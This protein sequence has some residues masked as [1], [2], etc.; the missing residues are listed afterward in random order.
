M[1][2]NQVNVAVLGTLMVTARADC[3]SVVQYFLKTAL[4]PLRYREGYGDGFWQVEVHPDGRVVPGG[5]ALELGLPERID[6]LPL[7]E[8]ARL[9]EE[10]EAE[11]KKLAK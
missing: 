9:A 2:I 10:A 5:Y 1:S 3:L 6:E 7:T 4:Q 8:L 11:I